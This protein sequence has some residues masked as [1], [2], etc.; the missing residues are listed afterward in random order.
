MRAGEVG[1]HSLQAQ[2]SQG[3]VST[4]SAR[5]AHGWHTCRDVHSPVHP[6]ATQCPMSTTEGGIISFCT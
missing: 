3:H 4:V 6:C 2:Q 5:D 1:K